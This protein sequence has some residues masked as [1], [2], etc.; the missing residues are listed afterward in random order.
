MKRLFLSIT[1]VILFAFSAFSQTI[2]AA[3]DAAK[4]MGKTVNIT[5]NVY[6][7][8]IMESGIIILSIGGYEPKQELTVMIPASGRNKFKGRPWED[9]KGKDVTVSGKLVS[10]NGKPA[11]IVSDPQQ[12]KVVL[13]DNTKGVPLKQN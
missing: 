1:L 6:D 5:E 3:K 4:H 12:L 13:I 9:Y 8:K 7:G 11:I 10:Y 2:I